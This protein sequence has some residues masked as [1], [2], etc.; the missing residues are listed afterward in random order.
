MET[1]MT[2]SID[3]SIFSKQAI[4]NTSYWYTDRI[5][6]SFQDESDK[7][8]NIKFQKRNNKIDLDMIINEFK[9]DLIDHELRVKL[10]KEFKLIREEI[11]NRA[12]SSVKK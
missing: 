1:E 6:I 5:F 2:I 11:V 3:T 8:I 9:N 7:K 12:F 10:N 4:M